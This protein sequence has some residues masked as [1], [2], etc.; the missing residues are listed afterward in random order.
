MDSFVV[1]LGRSSY[2]KKE[3]L[4]VGIRTGETQEEYFTLPED[5][6]KYDAISISCIS[7][8]GELDF[9]LIGEHYKTEKL[10]EQIKDD[11]LFQ[12]EAHFIVKGKLEEKKIEFDGTLFDALLVI[13]NE[14]AKYD[15]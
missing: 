12:R 9:M 5:E 1:W 10:L 6:G 13:A 14:G 8:K 4:E 7:Q 15:I 11:P 3:G 2:V